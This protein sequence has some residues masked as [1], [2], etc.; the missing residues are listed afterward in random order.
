MDINDTDR[1]GT[2]LLAIEMRLA[3]LDQELRRTQVRVHHLESQLED[4]NLAG[5]LGENAG[6]PSEIV[7]ALEAS[8]GSL[9]HQAALVERV[10]QSRW[11][12]RLAY[13]VARARERLNQQGTQS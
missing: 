5:L 11:K 8:R 3:E 13:S 7:P 2:R 4:A 10:K 6:D 12:A 1:L 9:E